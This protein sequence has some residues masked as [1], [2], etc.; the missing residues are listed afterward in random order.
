M[1]NIEGLYIGLY[2]G[3]PPLYKGG[4]LSIYAR[5]SIQGL[6][7]EKVCCLQRRVALTATLGYGN[8]KA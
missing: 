2:R 8:A 6:C 1:L 3:S 5:R 4:G 7:S